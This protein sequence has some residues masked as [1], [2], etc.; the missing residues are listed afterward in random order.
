[1]DNGD[2]P[3]RSF[4]VEGYRG[5]RSLTL[6]ELGRVNLFVGKN[7]AGKTSLLE[8]LSLFIHRNS[9]ILAAIL[10]DT[11]REHSDLPP[12]SFTATKQTP[13]AGDLE[14][15]VD[16]VEGLF[17][18]SFEGS[19]LRPI[20]V[21]TNG[22]PTGGIT[23]SLPWSDDGARS[24]DDGGGQR[25]AL[26]DPSSA[27]LRLRTERH[28]GG[29]PLEWFSRRIPVIQ[30]GGATGA[31]S[32]SAMG[33][34]AFDA[35]KLWDRIAIAGM[36]HLVED[37]LRAV[38]P[39]LDRVLLVGESASRTVLCALRGTARP[40]PIKSMGDGPNRVFGLAVAL[41][42][43]RGGALLIDEVE[44]GLHHTV[45]HEVWNA[46]FTLAERLNVQVFATTHSW[47]AVVAFQ[48]AANRSPAK[49]ML[50]RLER[51]DDDTIYVEK[52][53]EQDVARAAEYQVEVR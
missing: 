33:L 15:V 2:L 53:T 36:E 19:P 11:V 28:T 16:A 13:E 45:Q 47:D 25:P 42:E 5:I 48:D 17:H 50:Y 9:K 21:R 24:P 52:Y 27:L 35:R 41:V 1:M 29:V 34:G 3:L 12:P 46:I 22:P 23:I 39:D 26:I 40:V 7:N 10:L 32:I 18:G 43:S 6:P 49:G 4:T 14:R 8:A 44:N 30:R 31:L 51:E 20:T 38:V 37:A